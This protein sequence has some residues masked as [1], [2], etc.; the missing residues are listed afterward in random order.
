MI[1]Q[2]PSELQLWMK[3]LIYGRPGVGKTTLAATLDPERTLFLNI[4]GGMLSVT[5]TA[6]KTTSQLRSVA[7]VEEI[8][9][10]LANRDKEVA[11]VSTVVI[12]SATELQTISL[13]GLVAEGIKK[14]PERSPDD[15]HL[16]DYGRS[17]AQLKRLFR[18]FRDLPMHV[19]LTALVKDLTAGEE[20]KR[21]VAT[22]PY[23][24]EKLS[25]SLMGYQDFVWYLDVRDGKRV[26]CTQ[27]NAPIKAK[28]RGHRFSKAIGS[29]VIEPNL[30][31]LYEKL[32]ETETAS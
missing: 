18:L 1:I 30:K 17:T 23:L 9:W 28:T 16:R 29:Y 2:K 3:L 15:I 13:E 10:R 5:G 11:W 32:V 6:A 20:T 26:I 4:E 14:K 27:D 19:I 24:T 12:D 7:E 31:T 21:V 8:F 25:A 22:V